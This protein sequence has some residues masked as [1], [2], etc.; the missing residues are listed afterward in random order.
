MVNTGEEIVKLV[1]YYVLEEKSFDGSREELSKIK[2]SGFESKFKAVEYCM[3]Q[4][5][6]KV[7]IIEGEYHD[8]SLHIDGDS[9]FVTDNETDELFELQI[10]EK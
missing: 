10:K 2:V 5:L 3:K 8:Y 9:F 4:C 7:A 6:D 1:K